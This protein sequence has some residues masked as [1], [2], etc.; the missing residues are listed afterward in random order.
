MYRT[1]LRAIDVMK[2]AG[3]EIFSR[4]VPRRRRPGGSR[5][6]RGSLWE[7]RGSCLFCSP[8]FCCRFQTLLQPAFTTTEAALV[9]V[10]LGLVISRA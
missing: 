10:L 9:L 4:I 7:A 8:M 5:S 1:E 3:A 2:T 6:G